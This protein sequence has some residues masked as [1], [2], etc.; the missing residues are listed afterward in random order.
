M[1]IEQLRQ[2]HNNSKRNGSDNH[3]NATTVEEDDTMIEVL[4][5]QII[6]V[7]ERVI[8]NH[9]VYDDNDRTDPLP[10]QQYQLEILHPPSSSST[11]VSHGIWIN[12]NF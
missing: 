10:P 8:Q 9:T 12:W 4:Q 7:M 1:N 6:A 3:N 5:Q 11:R 2:R